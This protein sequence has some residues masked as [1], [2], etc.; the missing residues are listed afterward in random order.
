[1][2]KMPA[3]VAPVAN[4]GTLH[5]YTSRL[6]AFEHTPHAAPVPIPRA[7]STH[8]C[9]PGPAQ[10]KKS[11]ILFLAGLGDLPLSVHYT[12]RLAAALAP[13][14][15]LVEV[16][17][18]SVG[19]GWATGSLDRDARELASCVAYF[20]SLQAGAVSLG[21]KIVLMGHS[22]GCQVAC[23][24]ILG[25]RRSLRSLSS[26]PSTDDACGVG[27]GEAKERQAHEARPSVDAAILQACVSDA[28][29]INDALE[30][31][32]LAAGVAL[33][34]SWVASGRGGDVLPA[35]AGAAAV[36]GQSCSAER[37]LSLV[38][39]DGEGEDDWFATSGHEEAEERTWGK[40][41]GL[42]SWGKDVLVLWGGEDECVP[43]RVP[44]V[45]L[46]ARWVRRMETAGGVVGRGSGVVPG[47]GHNG[48]KSAERPVGELVRRVVEFV[49]QLD[50]RPGSPEAGERRR[51]L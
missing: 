17:L 19:A 27:M 13:G 45:E 41:G 23:R 7:P 8:A 9:A 26:A 4:T 40:D 47:L 18:S 34:R 35:E 16:T 38:S 31:A 32:E 25:R 28:D 22:T 42:G 43:K 3:A 24:Y 51:K 46:V 1:M 39:S 5:L 21:C 6:S 48:N 12:A 44:K 2:N 11:Y 15:A 30:S 36:F 20:R 50:D 37:W 14:W 29:A 10:M 49:T 33:A